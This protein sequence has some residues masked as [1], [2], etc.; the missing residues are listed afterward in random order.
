LHGGDWGWRTVTTPDERDEF[1]RIR[2]VDQVERD[3]AIVAQYEEHMMFTV[4]GSR[5]GCMSLVG[6]MNGWEESGSERG[7]E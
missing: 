3:R 5:T 7:P 6:S 4:R 2:I 1:A